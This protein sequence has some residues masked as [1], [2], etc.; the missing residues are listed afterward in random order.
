MPFRSLVAGVLLSVVPAFAAGQAPAPKMT[1]C[2]YPVAD[3]VVPLEQ[4]GKE[5]VKTQEAKLIRLIESTISPAAWQ[6]VGG[7]GAVEYFPLTMTLVVRQT[8]DVQEGVQDLL[9]ALRRAQETEVS[10]EMRFV[11]VPTEFFERLGLDV[12]ANERSSPGVTMLDDSQVR[13]LL[14]A[15]HGDRRANVMQAPKLTMFNGQKANVDLTEQQLYVVGV[16]FENKD[17]KQ[18]PRPVT[19]KVKTGLEISLLP[20]VS[21]DQ[22]KVTLQLGVQ[23]GCGE[24]PAPGCCSNQPRFTSVKLEKTLKLADGATAMLTGWTQQR[25]VRSEFGPPVLS[26]I[27]YVNRLFKNTSYGR[28]TEHTFV[29]VTPR[30]IV[31]KEQE[32]AV[33]AEQEEPK[34][35]AKPSTPDAGVM[36][37][38][39][40]SFELSYELAN[41]GPSKVDS[42]QVWVTRD[43]QKWEPYPDA[44]KP[45]STLPVTVKGD[46]KYGFTLVPRNGVGVCGPTPAEG[47]QPQVWVVVDT[48]KPTLELYKPEVRDGGQVVF[49]W[50]TED[51]GKLPDQP[52]CLYF[53]EQPCGPWRRFEEKWPAGPA[54]IA[55]KAEALPYQFYLRATVTDAAGN[56]AEAVTP[57]PVRIDTKV[58]AVRNVKVKPQ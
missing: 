6:C 8:A 24:P 39:K 36:Y 41:A 42:I 30:L 19:K 37:V 26:K 21:P 25:E 44:V 28:E 54:A 9:S 20:T 10:V 18:V 7:A 56:V 4:P 48:A 53:S 46:G 1:T 12:D 49:R 32:E 45:L 5:P 51:D 3:L 50:K 57:E 33:T 16:E 13:V 55:V 17:G 27:P 23:Y 52:V 29:L 14:E 43:G 22:K 2:V 31:N 38:N 35:P 58:P 40:K 34:A 15:I 47:D 11:T